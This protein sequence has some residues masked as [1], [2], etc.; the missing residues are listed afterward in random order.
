MLKINII[1]FHGGCFIGGNVNWD[2]KQNSFLEKCGYK[3]DQVAF[4]KRHSKFLKWM[5]EFDFTKY[6]GKIYILGRSSGGYLAKIFY[7]YHNRKCQGVIYLCPVFNPCFRAEIKPKFKTKTD[8]FFD[9]PPKSTENW[10]HEREIL[11]L[12]KDDQNVPNEL[13]TDDQL[14]SAYH[15]GPSSHI[16]MLSCTSDGFRNIL[17]ER[18][19]L[20]D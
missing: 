4:P 6:D 15:V 5:R 12:A 2:K 18:V 13:F 1:S 7:E 20:K 14:K 17:M 8:L 3:V 10:D 11:F 19:K 16:G 9:H